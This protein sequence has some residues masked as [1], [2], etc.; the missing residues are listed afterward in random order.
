[1]TQQINGDWSR[2]GERDAKEIPKDIHHF[3]QFNGKCGLVLWAIIISV[4]NNQRRAWEKVYVKKYV[5]TKN[6]V[7]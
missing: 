1:M 7:W 3:P 5:G 2:T 4:K 6:Y